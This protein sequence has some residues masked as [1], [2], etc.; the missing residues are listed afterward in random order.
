MTETS[1]P[2]TRT[3]LNLFANEVG[4][5][6]VGNLLIWTHFIEYASFSTLH[7][8]SILIRDHGSGTVDRAYQK[9]ANLAGKL[10][11]SGA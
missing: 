8:V 2:M 9:L 4:Q 5:N 1:R 10:H 7:C 11:T 6:I 3:A